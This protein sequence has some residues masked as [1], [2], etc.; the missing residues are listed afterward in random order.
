MISK[1]QIV[2]KYSVWYNNEKKILTSGISFIIFRQLFTYRHG[3]VKVLPGLFLYAF[4]TITKVVAPTT[5]GFA[6]RSLSN[7]TA[8]IAG[9][10]FHPVGFA[11]PVPILL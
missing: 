11:Q 6:M 10:S 8:A 2:T 3:W 9:P 5:A 7:A 1:K 4:R